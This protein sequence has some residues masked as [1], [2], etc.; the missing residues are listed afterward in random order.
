[1]KSLMADCSS[2]SS[3][4]KIIYPGRRMFGDILVA[5]FHDWTLLDSNISLLDAYTFDTQVN[6]G[7]FLSFIFG[8][9]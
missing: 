1:M 7:T 6:F 8:T 4:T 5:H 2:A 9:T 3:I